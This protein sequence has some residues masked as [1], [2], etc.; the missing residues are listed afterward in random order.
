MDTPYMDTQQAATYLGV[1]RRSLEKWRL[2]GAGPVFR[3]FGRRRLYNVAD[4]E[5]WAASRKARSTSE[6]DQGAA[7]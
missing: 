4:L 6:G 3:R 2:T 1:S 5:S 7:G